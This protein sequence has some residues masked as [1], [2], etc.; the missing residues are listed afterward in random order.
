MVVLNLRNFKQM[1]NQLA[2]L[3]IGVLAANA[4]FLAPA[5][6]QTE[7]KFYCGKAYDSIGKTN[8]PATVLSSPYRTKPITM[9][10]WKS[11]YFGDNFTPQ[12]RCA[13]VSPKFQAANKAGNLEFLK[14]GNDGKQPIVCGVRTE[15]QRCTKAGMLFTLKPFGNPQAELNA[16][17]E[18]DAS[19]GIYQSAESESKK[20]VVNSEGTVN[21]RQFINSAD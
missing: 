12:Q 14:I 5:Q 8:V 17:M 11:D 15:N 6:A 1:K 3:A 2:I 13:I 4:V 16:L 19:S 9:I 20:V 21:I 18:G 10:L 7:G